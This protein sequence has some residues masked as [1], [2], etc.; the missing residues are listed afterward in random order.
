MR[1]SAPQV[2]HVRSLRTLKGFHKQTIDRGQ[3]CGTPLGFMGF[4]LVLPGVRR[5]HGNPRLC[6]ETPVGVEN[7]KSSGRRR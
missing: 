6:C 7:R 3:L 2:R 1:S 4:Y 5:I